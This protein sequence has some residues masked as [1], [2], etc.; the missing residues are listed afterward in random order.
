MPKAGP[1]RINFLVNEVYTYGQPGWEPTDTRL[2]GTERGVVEWAE[3]LVNRDHQVTVYRNHRE[4]KH[5]DYRGITFKDRSEYADDQD[6]T[7]NVK[8]PDLAPKGPTLFYTNDV[9]ADKQDLS[10]YNGVVHISE[11]ALENIPVNNPNR[12]VV[13]HGISPDI[14]PLPKRSK[15]CLYAS[16]PDRGLDTLLRVWPKV[17]RAHPDA[18]LLVTYGAD[19]P[20]YDG[21]DYLGEVDEETMHQLFRESE[22]WI[23]PANGG[24]LQCITGMKAQAAGCWPIYFPIM[25]LSETVKFGTKSTPETL[26]KDII[27]AMDG[28]Y[29]LPDPLPK[30]PTIKDSTDR[31]LEV[32]NSVLGNKNANTN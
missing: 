12:F 23:H 27:S 11:W 26:A 5:L 21:I 24:E 30:Q 32:I 29:K 8:S 22:F 17:I 18:T 2:S 19:G 16:S 9:D 31:L 3:E 6:V 10:A 1:L 4:Y 15:Q 28:N 14:T 13:Q 25:A 20:V 7:I